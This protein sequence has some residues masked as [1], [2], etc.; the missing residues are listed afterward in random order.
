MITIHQLWLALVLVVSSI[1]ETVFVR[2]YNEDYLS[3]GYFI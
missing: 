2:R 1:V 3:F